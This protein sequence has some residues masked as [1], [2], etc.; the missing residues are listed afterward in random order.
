MTS[1]Q[2]TTVLVLGAHAAA[3]VFVWTS[4]SGLK[5]LLSL[6]AIVA[7]AVLVYAASRIRYIL[8]AK[9]FSYGALIVGELLVLSAAAWAFRGHRSAVIVSSV[10]FGLHSCA[11]VA[12]VLFAFLFKMTRLM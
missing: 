3:L 12:A 2:T 1:F 9:D 11:S 5:V 4:P 10:A 7:M 6:N 8:A